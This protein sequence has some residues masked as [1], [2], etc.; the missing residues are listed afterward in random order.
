MVEEDGSN[1]RYDESMLPIL[2]KSPLLK[3]VL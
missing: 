1:K 3:D 2:L